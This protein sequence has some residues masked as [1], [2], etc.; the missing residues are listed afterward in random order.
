[1]IIMKP[2][3]ENVS[4]QILCKAMQGDGQLTQHSGHLLHGGVLS[5][6]FLQKPI[7]EAC[8]GGQVGRVH[9]VPGAVLAA[10]VGDRVESGV[11][12]GVVQSGADGGAGQGGVCI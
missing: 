9:Q 12:R 7:R 2:M 8:T 1:M 10:V 5:S 4:D 3:T 6:Q 11:E